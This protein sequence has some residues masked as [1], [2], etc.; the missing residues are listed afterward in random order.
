MQYIAR[1][2]AGLLLAQTA[3]GVP[4]LGNRRSLNPIYERTV[5]ENQER[6]I[7]SAQAA[8]DNKSLELEERNGGEIGGSFE[9]RGGTG[10]NLKIPINFK[11][12]PPSG[13]WPGGPCPESTS[14]A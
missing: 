2:L 7:S 5:P 14:P 3:A 10:P 13:G 6:D 4:Y 12:V 1:F 9:K 11:I 8:E